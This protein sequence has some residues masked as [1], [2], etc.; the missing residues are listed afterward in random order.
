MIYLIEKSDGERYLKI[1]ERYGAFTLFFEL[2]NTL[3]NMKDISKI[4]KDFT[5]YTIVSFDLL[6]DGSSESYL[7]FVITKPSEDENLSKLTLN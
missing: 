4:N 1:F 7:T 5:L 3:N 2:S 6:F